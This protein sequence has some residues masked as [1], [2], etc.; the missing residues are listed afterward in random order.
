[1]AAGVTVSDGA[2]PTVAAWLTGG[3][4]WCG[5]S[6]D[7]GWLKTTLPSVA[8]HRQA[9]DTPLNLRRRDLFTG[10]STI[11]SNDSTGG[12]SRIGAC[13]VTTQACLQ[14]SAFASSSNCV[15]VEQAAVVGCN[16]VEHALVIDY[17]QA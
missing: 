14:S 6:S 16:V 9:I 8:G 3:C 11:I 1:M 17:W 10:L 4:V 13:S 5:C 7:G 2:L 12:L 15:V